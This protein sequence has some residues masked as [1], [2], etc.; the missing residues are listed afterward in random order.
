NEKIANSLEEIVMSIPEVNELKNLSQLRKELTELE[1]QLIE[2]ETAMQTAFDNAKVLLDKK[3]G[4]IEEQ[5]RIYAFVIDTNILL[6]DPEVIL[7]VDKK[8]SIIIAA[9]VLDELDKFKMDKNLSTIVSR[10]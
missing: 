5:K 7:R 6:E 1:R 8:H 10:A 2:A 4:E 3:Q 9:K